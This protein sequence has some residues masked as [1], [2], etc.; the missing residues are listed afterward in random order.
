MWDED[1]E[2]AQE[3]Y[4]YAYCYNAS[5]PQFSEF[6]EIEISNDSGILRRIG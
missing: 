4:A 3:H 1:K 5:H 6:G 2:S